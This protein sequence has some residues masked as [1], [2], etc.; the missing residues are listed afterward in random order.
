MT[1]ALGSKSGGLVVGAPLVVHRSRT[2]VGESLAKVED[3]RWREHSLFG[4]G[5]PGESWWKRVFAPG[6]AALLVWRRVARGPRQCVQYTLVAE[7]QAA[8]VG[9]LHL[10]SLEGVPGRPWLGNAFTEPPKDLMRLTNPI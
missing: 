6:G 9:P 2:T 5:R 3:D 1:A 10:G 8:E 7:P 4:R